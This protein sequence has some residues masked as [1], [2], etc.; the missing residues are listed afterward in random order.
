MRFRGTNMV[1][2]IM[3]QIISEYSQLEEVEAITIAG[4]RASM[5]NDEQSDIDI[6]LFT[7]S[8]ISVDKRREIA[9]KFSSNIEINNQFFGVGDEYFLKDTPIEIDVCFFDWQ[10]ILTG[11]ERVIKHHQAS[12]SYTTC[13]VHNVTRAEVIFDRHG[14]FANIQEKYRDVYSQ[15]LKENIVKMNYPI[16]RDCFSSYYAQ[17]EKAIHHQDLN[18]INH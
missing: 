13:F 8:P 7:T 18:S 10:A 2:G 16:L 9:S 11:L 1:E 6:D 14:N 15:E 3:K 12:T 4:S 5:R 17:I